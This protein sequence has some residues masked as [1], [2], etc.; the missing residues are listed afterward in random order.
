MMTRARSVPMSSSI[1]R[2]LK[3]SDEELSVKRKKRYGEDTKKISLEI[4]S[5]GA[6]ALQ[7]ASDYIKQ[8]VILKK[9]YNILLSRFRKPRRPYYG[10]PPPPRLNY[11]TK[12]WKAEISRRK[13]AYE[14]GVRMTSS[15][16]TP[17]PYDYCRMD[18]LHRVYLSSLYGHSD[19][20]ERLE[21]ARLIKLLPDIYYIVH[22]RRHY[23]ATSKNYLGDISPYLGKIGHAAYVI[24]G[25][26]EREAERDEWERAA[27]ILTHLPTLIPRHYKP[28]AGLLRKPLSLTQ[29]AKKARITAECKEGKLVKLT[30]VFPYCAALPVQMDAD[31]YH[32]SFPLLITKIPV[33]SVAA[34]ERQKPFPDPFAYDWTRR[35]AELK[36]IVDVQNNLFKS[37]LL[38]YKTEGDIADLITALDDS[39]FNPAT[40]PW[41]HDRYASVRKL[42]GSS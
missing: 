18:L 28:K 1:K 42:R 29:Q 4:I 8:P 33:M 39:L 20:E 34:Y 30:N 37:L 38:D 40:Y 13:A 16:V 10:S 6:A 14:P 27:S 9:G 35:T 11:D 5:K 36:R 21:N 19:L 32:K 26:E 24:V 7:T 41:N 15:P 2:G 17:T 3:F 22:P 23:S 25:D 12:D 31:F